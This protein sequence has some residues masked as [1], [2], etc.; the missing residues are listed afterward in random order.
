MIVP[1]EK[2]HHRVRGRRRHH[3]PRPSPPF[4]LFHF[5]LLFL[6]I[7]I[8]IEHA[9]CRE[10]DDRSRLLYADD[11]GAASIILEYQLHNAPSKDYSGDEQKRAAKEQ[12]GSEYDEERHIKP[13]FLL[14]DNG[15]RVVQYYSPWCGHCQ[16]FKS[17][18]ISLAKEINARLP[19]DQPEVNFHAV[20]CSVYHW[21]C[22]QN[23]VK[24][25]PKI[26]AFQGDSI[27]PTILNEKFMTAES[28]A[29]TVGVQLNAPV[30][31]GDTNI[32]QGES[33]YIDGNEAL[34]AV[35]ILGATLNGLRRTHDAVYMDAALSFTHALKTGVFSKQMY[36]QAAPLDSFQR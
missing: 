15:P 17:K 14:P 23:D 12:P 25:F 9:Q 26:V 2:H 7:F 30:I 34:H 1:F 16:F 27:I 35:D 33:E 19:D 13:Y 4:F 11:P 10:A 3:R 21:V 6:S 22:L 36:G 31:M 32:M 5:L 8:N 28:I 18:Y 24:D 20:S 29:Q